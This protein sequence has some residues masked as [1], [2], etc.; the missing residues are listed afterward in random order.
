MDGAE[1]AA[2]LPTAQ[3]LACDVAAVGP[4]FPFTEGEFVYIG[5]LEDLRCIVASASAVTTEDVGIVPG[6]T[7]PPV[8][9]GPVNRLGVGVSTFDHQTV[10]E[11]AIDGHLKGMVIGAEKTLPQ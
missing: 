9:V 6:E 4:L 8:I 10:R 2:G 5:Q 11:L 3:G 7:G 1:G